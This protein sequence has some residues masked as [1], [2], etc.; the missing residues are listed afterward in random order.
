[1][2]TKPIEITEAELWRQLEDVQRKMDEAIAERD[3]AEAEAANIRARLSNAEQTIA[4]TAKV[5]VDAMAERDAALA[6]ADE[7]E[8]LHASTVETAKKALALADHERARAEQAIAERN[9]ARQAADDAVDGAWVWSDADN[10]DTF[11][12]GAVLRITAE[13]LRMLLARQSTEAAP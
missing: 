12:A 3:A 1:M 11:A 4:A 13:Q 9:A 8:T 2:E 10:I 5:G 7:W 6:R